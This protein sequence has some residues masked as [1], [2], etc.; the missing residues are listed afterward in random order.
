MY[1]IAVNKL[2]PQLSASAVSLSKSDLQEIIASGATKLLFA[3]DQKRLVGT[4]TLVMFKIPTGTRTRIEDLIVDSDARGHGIGK[5]LIRHAIKLAKDTGA[6]AIDLTSH[7][8]RE[9]ANRLY[10]KLGFE[11]RETNVYRYKI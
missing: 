3:E 1:L 10:Q 8:L 6:K 7:P 2:L 9:P 4:L 11:I 5:M